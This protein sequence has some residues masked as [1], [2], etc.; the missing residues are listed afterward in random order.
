[1]IKLIKTLSDDYIMTRLSVKVVV[2][3]GYKGQ[4][5]FFF[6]LFLLLLKSAPL[7]CQYIEVN[8]GICLREPFTPNKKNCAMRVMI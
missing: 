6:I 7:V 5:M 8:R 2:K 3:A 4:E 1:M